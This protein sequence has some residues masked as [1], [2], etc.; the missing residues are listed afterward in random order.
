MFA[1]SSRSN[2]SPEIVGRTRSQVPVAI[3]GLRWGRLWASAACL[4]GATT[5]MRTS[6][7]TRVRAK[8]SSLTIA[9]DSVSKINIGSWTPVP[10]AARGKHP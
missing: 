8:I 5:S 4:R 7:G 10:R 9:P 6:Y 1:R 2:S 3:R